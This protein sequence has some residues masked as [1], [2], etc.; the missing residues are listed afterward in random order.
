MKRKG[1]AIGA[2]VVVLIV[3]VIAWIAQ[4]FGVGKEEKKAGP[5]AQVQIA[6][7]QRKTVTEKVIAYGSVQADARAVQFKAG[8]ESR[9]E[10]C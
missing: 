8:H 10:R 9:P 5:V 1:M 7:V 2:I 6:K 4:R 3:C